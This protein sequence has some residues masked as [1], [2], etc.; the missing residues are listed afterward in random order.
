MV[1]GKYSLPKHPDSQKGKKSFIVEA[2]NKQKEER[3]KRAWRKGKEPTT[4]DYT[5]PSKRN[6]KPQEGAH[7]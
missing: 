4:W 3:S 5:W 6:C 2:C 7:W 1:P